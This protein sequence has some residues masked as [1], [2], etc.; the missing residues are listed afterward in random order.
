M[1]SPQNFGLCLGNRRKENCVFNP[2]G[3]SAM[4]WVIRFE[5]KPREKVSKLQSVSLTSLVMVTIALLIKIRQRLMA[6]AHILLTCP[7][8]WQ[9]SMIHAYISTGAK[10]E[11]LATAAGTATAPF[12]TITES[13]S[14]MCA[15]IETLSLRKEKNEKNIYRYCFISECNSAHFKRP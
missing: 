15:F 11:A 4:A 9:H 1:F 12:G 10:N 5:R 13:K 7:S 6:L 8:K 14:L 2:Q 3:K